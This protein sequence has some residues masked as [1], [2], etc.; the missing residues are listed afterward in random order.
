MVQS[1]RPVQ[2][3]WRKVFVSSVYLKPDFSLYYEIIIKYVLNYTLI[4]EANSINF[5]AE[6]KKKTEIN[7]K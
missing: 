3:V 5:V 1:W 2:R 7:I 4:N 6:L